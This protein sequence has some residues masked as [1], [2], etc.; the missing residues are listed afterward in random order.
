MASPRPPSARCTADERKQ[1]DLLSGVT[2]NILSNNENHEVYV[3][4]ARQ[5]NVRDKAMKCL[6]V[7]ATRADFGQKQRRPETFARSLRTWDSSCI[8]EAF[9]RPTTAGKSE[10]AKELRRHRQTAQ[11]STPR[12]FREFQA[13]RAPTP[14]LAS[15]EP[16]SAAGTAARWA[17]PVGNAPS[18]GT[19]RQEW[20]TRRGE[21]TLSPQP[22]TARDLYRAVDQL[23]AQPPSGASTA[24][25]RTAR[26]AASQDPDRQWRHHSS[27]RVEPS[28]G[29]REISEWTRERPD[30]V[31]DKLQR[32]DPF[33]VKPAASASSSTVKYDIVTNLPLNFWY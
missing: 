33:F 17:I 3:P 32:Q 24:R 4:D 9:S 2:W 18:G 25:E 8:R 30:K 23:R 11:A 19:T 12:S 28:R 27:R 26:S 14:S 16:G 15:V 7:Q 20:A 5:I 6:A 1:A 22:P 10:R 21:P 29:G 13:I 31:S